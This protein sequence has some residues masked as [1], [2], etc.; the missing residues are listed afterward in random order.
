[1]SNPSPS[2]AALKAAVE[3]Y[4]GHLVPTAQVAAKASL[5]TITGTNKK[6]L[7]IR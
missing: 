7:K 1:M 3:T 4:M 6:V 2:D 5:R